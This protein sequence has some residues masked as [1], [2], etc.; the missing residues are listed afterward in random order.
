MLIM[1]YIQVLG[2]II[3]VIGGGPTLFLSVD[4]VNILPKKGGQGWTNINV[5]K[6]AHKILRSWHELIIIAIM[7]DL[8]ASTD[9]ES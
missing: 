4:F 6:S 1:Y 7:H 5:H 3:G 2:V 8:S 9:Q